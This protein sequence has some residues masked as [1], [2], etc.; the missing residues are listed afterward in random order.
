VRPASLRLSYAQY[1]SLQIAALCHAE[2]ALV[3]SEPG[4]SPHTRMPRMPSSP[5]LRSLRA[6]NRPRFSYAPGPRSFF[7]GNR[8]G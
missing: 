3:H 6:P 1:L 7:R 8:E 2:L 5:R 4:P